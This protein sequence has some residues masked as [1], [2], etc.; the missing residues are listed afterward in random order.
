M[1]TPPPVRP[2]YATPRT[3]DRYSDGEAF[4]LGIARWLGRRPTAWQQSALDVALERVDGPGSPYAFDTVVIVV[5]R[6]AGKTVTAFGVPLIRA[7]AGPVHLP[8]G[9]IVPF[10]ATHTAQNLQAAR[11]RFT[12][13]MVEPYRR[14]FSDVDWNRAAEAR[15]GQGDTKLTVDPIRGRARKNLAAARRS[16][17]AS[18]LRVLAPTPGNARGAGVLHRTIDEALTFDRQRGEELDAAARPT[19][20]EFQGYAQAWMLSNV[21][22]GSDEFTH[23]WHV[24]NKGRAAVESGRTEGICYIEYSLPPDADPDDER[25]WWDHYPGLA[26]GI[27]GIRQLRRDREELG[28]ATFA[29][30]YLCR[31]PDENPAGVLLW[32]VITENDW[33]HAATTTEQ[34]SDADA[35]IGVDI[36]PF[37]RSSSIVAA[38]R[39]PERDGVLLEVVDHR[40]GSTWVADAVRG[41]A[42]RVTGIGIDDYGPG[43]DLILALRDDYDVAARIQPLTAQAMISASYALDNGLRESTVRYRTHPALTAAAAAAQRTTGKAWIW[44]RRVKTSQAPLVAASI[45]AYVLDYAARPAEAPAVF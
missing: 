34:P 23:L 3:L 5:G 44:E 32:P 31:W 18:E 45:A 10:R 29:A 33:T 36:D 41:L 43:H 22:T 1:S 11:Q 8:N 35:A 37:G 25:A 19:M 15:Y 6:R 24:R 17:R 28:A 42:G 12:E 21:S 2:S 4:G 7:L 9:R 30:E 16:G 39:D 13:D 40:P 38:V 14:R 27:V 20:A 26:D